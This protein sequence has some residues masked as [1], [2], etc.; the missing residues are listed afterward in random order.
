[1]DTVLKKIVRFENAYIDRYIEF[2][3][4]IA[5]KHNVELLIVG[6]A[7]RE[8]LLNKSPKDIDFIV[9]KGDAIEVPMEL[10]RSA[11]FFYPV[12]FEKFGNFRTGIHNDYNIQM[13]FVPIRAKNIIDDLLLRDFTINTLI[14][15]RINRFSYEISDL[16]GRAFLALENKILQTPVDA[17]QTIK[18]DPL[19]ILRAIRFSCIL[20]FNMEQSLQDT[21]RSN[22][23]LINGV[24]AE[25]IREELFM[26]M[27]SQKPSKGIQ[28][29]N[30]LG[31]LD[32]LM[33]EIKITVGFDQRSHYH[34]DELFIHSLEVM[35]KTK[36]NISTRLAA[37]F[38]DV[39][40]PLSKHEQGKKVTYYGHQDKSSELFE[41]FARR[42]KIPY[43]IAAT[44][45]LLIKRHMINYTSDWKDST[46]K[47]FIRTNYDI[48]DK[49]LD[50]H[51][52][53]AS[54]LADQD[55]MLNGVNEFES[56][57]HE[58][59][60]DEVGR[61]ESPL[62]GSEI[63]NLLNIPPGPKIGEIKK[64]VVDAILEGTIE[65]TKQSAEA[66]IKKVYAA[67]K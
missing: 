46:I 52:A 53:D 28:L 12:S 23:S 40:K 64:A 24:A 50:L 27:N 26:I 60:L 62:D 32:V 3:D 61:L 44:A 1:M 18:D 43:S 54:S 58:Q 15:K 41:A 55:Y 8:L 19:R 66:F 45:G 38:H 56:R 16:L 9:V 57:I 5:K 20:E 37:L 4:E 42:L 10:H 11:G 13:E 29:M 2:A 14:M 6:G 33:P 30:E 59:K 51:R 65:P 63:Q 21:I 25:R 31:I 22:V 49:L 48:L 39:G 34:K 36:P 7:P 17:V 47:K 67:S 35:D